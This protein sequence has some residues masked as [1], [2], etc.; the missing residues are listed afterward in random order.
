MMAPAVA[1]RKS[2][3]CPRRYDENWDLA[4]LAAA[5]GFGL[6]KNHPYR[7]GNNESD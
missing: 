4:L 2:G 6:V 5:Y 7:D 1:G 3:M